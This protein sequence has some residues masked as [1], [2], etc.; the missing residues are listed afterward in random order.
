MNKYT[1]RDGAP[2]CATR[3]EAQAVGARIFF[4]GKPCRHG[5][6]SVRLTATGACA[7]CR[8]EQHRKSAGLSSKRRED[9]LCHLGRD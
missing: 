7:A 2:Q 1:F 9:Y 5:H 6:V 4:T 8:Q 3:E